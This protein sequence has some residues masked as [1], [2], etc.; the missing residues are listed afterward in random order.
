MRVCPGCGSPV[1]G[2]PN[3]IHCSPRCSAKFRA[4]EYRAQW[5]PEK[6]KAISSK[7]AAYRHEHWEQN[8]ERYLAANR[9]WEATHKERSNELHK[10]R[11]RKIRLAVIERYGRIC[12]CCGEGRMEFLAID[13]V[14]GG[15]K[16][17]RAEN[18][19]SGPAYYRALLRGERQFGLRVLCHNCNSAL[20]FY[21]YCP[22]SHSGNEA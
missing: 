19:R 17:H 5:S 14:N 11:N 4:R 16:A 22:H 8:K 2:R 21:G 7:H 6:R 15:G 10:Q 20:G 3:K 18:G 13:H 12:E 1:Q 9:R